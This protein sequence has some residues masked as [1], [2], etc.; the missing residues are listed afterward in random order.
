MELLVTVAYLGFTASR[1]MNL[2]FNVIYKYSF[3]HCRSQREH[4]MSEN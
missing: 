4:G 1:S 2:E 3:L